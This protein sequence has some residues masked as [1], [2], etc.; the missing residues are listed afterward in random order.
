[1]A[2]LSNLAEIV[3]LV[4]DM[5]FTSKIREVAKQLGVSV[6]AARDPAGLAKAARGARL[7]VLDLRLE[8][9]LAALDEVRKQPE[10]AALP[11]VGFIDHERVDV[12]DEARARGITE[13]MA[14]GQF[15]NALPRL[16]K[17]PAATPPEPAKTE[18]TEG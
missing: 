3:Y 14:K 17:S 8:T 18:D 1:L 10:L 15:A 13:V 7:V 5:L 16:L 11:A 9:A 2:W 6:E 12:M 4:R